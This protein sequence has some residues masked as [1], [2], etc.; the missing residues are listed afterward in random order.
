MEACKTRF[1]PKLIKQMNEKSA[2]N[3]RKNIDDI[4]LSLKTE[5]DEEKK[6]EL[7]NKK[8]FW[9]D[10]LKI[11]KQN[12]KKPNKK[13]LLKLQNYFVIQGVWVRQCKKPNIRI[14]I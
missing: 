6:K 8:K 1:V 14:K 7:T 9:E 11:Q 13:G 3:S 2:R 5:T 10:L 4:N 12:I